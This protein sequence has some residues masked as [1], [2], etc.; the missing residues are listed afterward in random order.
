MYWN[1]S[2]ISDEINAISS[3]VANYHIQTLNKEGLN[4]DDNKMKVILKSMEAATD[5][6]IAKIRKDE[7]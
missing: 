2:N 1:Y 6:V 3:R 4:T 5:A 7:K